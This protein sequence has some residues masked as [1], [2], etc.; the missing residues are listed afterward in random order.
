MHD[1]MFW[2][3]V[4]IYSLATVICLVA[5]VYHI[6]REIKHPCI[7]S[8]KELVHHPAVTNFFLIGGVMMPI[9]TPAHDSWE[10]VCDERA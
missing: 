1:E 10:D 3:G 7:R 4:A 2:W 5:T 6:R 8:H 9:T